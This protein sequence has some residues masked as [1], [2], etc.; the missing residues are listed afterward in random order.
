M[1]RFLDRAKSDFEAALSHDPRFTEAMAGMLTAVTMGSDVRNLT[2][3]YQKFLVQA[4][5]SYV[6]DTAMI[7][8]LAPR[9]KAGGADPLQ[10]AKK[11]S[12]KSA[13]HTDENLLTSYAHCLAADDFVADENVASAR[14]ELR[15]GMVVPADTD[16]SCYAEQGMVERAVGDHAA[17]IKA[18]ALYRS[19]GGA[20]TNAKEADSWLQL[21]QYEKA[22]TLFTE[23][24]RFRTQSPGLLCGRAEAEMDLGKIEQ[25]RRD[26]NAGLA[27]DPGRAYCLDIDERLVHRVRGY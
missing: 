21:K 5:H 11:K 23:G 10:F 16:I 24:L 1:Q 13:G 27:S 22:I 12:A 26:V 17:A 2:S 25:A 15:A 14:A 6:L 19:K 18:F 4:P 8:G 20:T 7:A 3:T 9:W